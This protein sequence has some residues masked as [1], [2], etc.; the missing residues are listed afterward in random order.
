MKKVVY[1]VLMMV[2][3]LLLS[4]LIFNVLSLM[5]TSEDIYI[6]I[7]GILCTLWWYWLGEYWWA[8]IYENRKNLKK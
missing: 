1:V 4:F 7:I 8:Y 6:A 3:L 2:F 5:N